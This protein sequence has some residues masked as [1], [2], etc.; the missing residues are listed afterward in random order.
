MSDKE[1]RFFNRLHR[2][3]TVKVYLAEQINVFSSIISSISSF[4]FKVYI[5]IEAQKTLNI[6]KSDQWMPK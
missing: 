6:L 2:R 4:F 5:R 1:S 3:S